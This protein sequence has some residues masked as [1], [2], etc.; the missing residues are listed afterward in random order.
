MMAVLAGRQTGKTKFIG[1]RRLLLLLVVGSLLFWTACG[2]SE[3]RLQLGDPAPDFTATDQYGNTIRLADLAGGPVV[4][5]FWSVDCKYCRA[6]TPI[7]NDYYRR[8]QDQ[9]LT[10]I[11]ISLNEDQEMVRRFIADLEIEF[12]VII[13]QGGRIAE[14]YRIKLD[15][16]AVFID[17]DHKLA[18]AV[19]GGVGEEEMARLLGGYLQ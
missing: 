5:R 16:Q 9:G 11:Y 15:P 12:P 10:V 2:K 13:D 18:T 6:D 14:K 3:R 19:L 7:F 4:L 17:P 1:G 8:Y